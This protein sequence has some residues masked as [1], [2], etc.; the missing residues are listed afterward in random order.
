MKEIKKYLT[1]T[2]IVIVL[3][4]E[5]TVSVIDSIFDV[6][7][8][9]ISDAKVMAFS[10]ILLFG[11]QALIFIIA[12]IVFT[13]FADRRINKLNDEILQER[14]LLFTNIAHD[15]KTP[16]T[17]VI[18]YA[19]ALKNQMV[20]DQAGQQEMLAAITLKAEKVNELLDSMFQYTK[21][22]SAGFNLVLEEC[23]LV[24]LLK[25]AIADYYDMFQEKYIS[26]ELDIQDEPILVCIN[27][28]EMR[29][30]FSN[31]IINAYKHNEPNSRVLIQI[32]NDCNTKVL[33]ADDGVNIS[34]HQ[35]ELF[36]P[37]INGSESRDGTSGSGLGLA[38]VKSIVDKHGFCIHMEEMPEPYTKAF[39]LTFPK[40]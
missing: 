11:V 17:T 14:N 35:N 2:F 6:M 26:L 28:A 22:N 34:V 18:G 27:Q 24:G 12:A 16:L 32:Q 3:V 36:D 5:I 20:T 29:R 23:N 13:H 38:I 15:L 37:F 40:P 39:I 33:F 7:A 4:M 10:L 25:E 30:A 21:F 9:N 8:N 31:L 1:R 19:R